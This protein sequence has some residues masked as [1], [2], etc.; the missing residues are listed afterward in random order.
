MNPVPE[1]AQYWYDPLPEG[2][3]ERRI[4]SLYQLACVAYHE[5]YNEEHRYRREAFL[6]RTLPQYTFNLKRLMCMAKE[7][8]QDEQD[9]FGRD[10]PPDLILEKHDTIKQ[11]QYFKHPVRYNPF[12]WRVVYCC[13]DPNERSGRLGVL[14]GP[15]CTA[16]CRWAE[17]NVGVDRVNYIIQ[18]LQANL[19]PG[20]NI[21][22]FWH[23]GIRLRLYLPGKWES[24]SPYHVESV[25]AKLG[26]LG[27]EEVEEAS[28]TESTGEEAEESRALKRS[29]S[30]E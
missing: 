9:V 5:V 22:A 18:T 20:E 21:A 24:I 13:E 8:P 1:T 3:T 30:M 12:S 17:F 19:P 14:V 27:V 11:D 4:P 23:W 10:T 2:T 7:H 29:R 26:E 16:P 28:E 25:Q 15:F 6:G